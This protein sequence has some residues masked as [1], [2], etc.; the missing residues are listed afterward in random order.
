MAVILTWL[1]VK[2]LRRPGVTGD[3]GMVG[4]VGTIGLQPPTRGRRIV[5]VRGELWWCRSSGTLEPGMEVRVTGVDGFV[6]EVVPV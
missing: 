2:A 4:L 3:A 5:E 1:G 6:L